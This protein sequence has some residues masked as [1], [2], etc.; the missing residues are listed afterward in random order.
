LLWIKTFHIIFVASWFAGLFYLPRIFVNLAML[1][2]SEVGTKERLIL[3][4]EKLL[5]FMSILMVPSVLLG[6][7]LWA[8]YGIGYSTS[9]AW[10]NVKLGL[11]VLVLAYHFYCYKIL[12]NIKNNNSQHSHIW[13]RWFNEA[14]VVLMVFIVALV[15]HKPSDL[16][17]FIQNL[18]GTLLLVVVA[19]LLINRLVK[20]YKSKIKE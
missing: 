17:E 15:V 13:F 2:D 20:K 14:P 9:Q 7:M 10:M 8:Y 4:A 19:F 5:R 1:S 11:V 18:L 16:N 6:I 3:M 12:G